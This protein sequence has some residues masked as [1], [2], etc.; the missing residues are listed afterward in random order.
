MTPLLSP[1]M[2]VWKFALMLTPTQT[3]QIADACLVRWVHAHQRSP[4]LIELWGIVQPQP[5]AT[6]RRTLHIR[7]TGHDLTG[8]EGRHIATLVNDWSGLVWHLFTDASQE[9]C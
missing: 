6:D 4:S 2:Q 3:I 9:A 8:D 5:H 1:G 7:G